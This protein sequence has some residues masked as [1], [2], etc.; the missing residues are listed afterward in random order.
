MTSNRPYATPTYPASPAPTTASSLNYSQY[1]TGSFSTPSRHQTSISVSS[2]SQAPIGALRDMRNPQRAHTDL[3]PK[4]TG[5]VKER[6]AESKEVAKVHWKALREFLQEWLQKGWSRVQAAL[7]SRIPHG[8]SVRQRETHA[9]HKV[10]VP[11]TVDGCVR[12]VDAPNRHGKRHARQ[13]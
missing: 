5:Q 11:R 13:L 1:G 12:R 9:T 10:T 8:Q 3:A 2:S 6:R 4:T 7:T